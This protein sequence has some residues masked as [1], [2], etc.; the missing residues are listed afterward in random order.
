M[1]CRRA[2]GNE[3]EARD[4]A[5][6]TFLKLLQSIDHIKT[7]EESNWLFAV[8]RNLCINLWKKR[9]VEKEHHVAASLDPPPASTVDFAAT[10]LADIFKRCQQLKEIHKKCLIMRYVLGMSLEEISETLALSAVQIKGHL[11]Y[12]LKIIRSEL[13]LPKE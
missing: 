11:Q 6:E 12:G 4:T 10:E 5:Q 8:A 3:E 1:Y 9:Q 2:L 13:K 7:G